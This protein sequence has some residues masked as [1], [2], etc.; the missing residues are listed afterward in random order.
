MSR[1]TLV[2]IGL[3]SQR[4]RVR[5]KVKVRVRVMVKVMLKVMVRVLGVRPTVQ[6]VQETLN[7]T[8]S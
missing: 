6:L 8:G 3:G 7:Q 2:V 1:F 4:Y 5:V